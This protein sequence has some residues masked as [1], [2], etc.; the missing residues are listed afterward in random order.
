MQFNEEIARKKLRVSERFSHV[1]ETFNKSEVGK[2]IAESTIESLNQQF[3]EKKKI[4][5]LLKNKK[6]K[7]V[8]EGKTYLASEKLAFTKKTSSSGK[9]TKR[10]GQTPR[11]SKKQKK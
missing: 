2:R 4:I 5:E 11:K 8:A 6:I 1:E 7:R 10:E 3:L 9:N